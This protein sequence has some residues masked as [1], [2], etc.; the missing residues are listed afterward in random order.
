MTERKSLD[1]QFVG[2][3][4]RDAM[5]ALEDVR[6]RRKWGDSRSGSP[7]TTNMLCAEIARLNIELEKLRAALNPNEDSR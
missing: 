2:K 5:K 7:I 6:A 4:N 1:A 3:V